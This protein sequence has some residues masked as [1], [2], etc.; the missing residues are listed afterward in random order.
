MAASPRPL[1]TVVTPS[2]N[3]GRFIEETIQSV[4]AQDY[5]PVEH[6]VF[7]AGSTDETH[8]VLARYEGKIRAVIAADD[9]QADAINRG[10]RA[11]A[12]TIV[13]WLNSDDV[14][15]PGAIRTAVEYLEAHPQCAMVYGKGHHIDAEGRF[16]DPYPTAPPSELEVFC[17]VCQPASFLRLA[18]VHAVGYLDPN[19]RYCMDY[20]LWLRLR[21]QFDIAYIPADLARSR[22]HA[23]AKSVSQQRAFMREIIGMTMRRIGRAPLVYL[24]GYANMLVCE[25][26]RERPLPTP[27]RRLAAG[28]V[29][30]TLALRYHRRLRIGEIR[31]ALNRAIEISRL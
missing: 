8:S 28:I 18:A 26:F 16:L 19:L 20:D 11:A 27:I 23:D 3:Q 6:L 24:Y 22:L 2:L 21:E 4:L 29:T 5:E 13:T 15:E 14:Y 9:G 12:G 10:F 31:H 17:T 30:A 25:R 1:V 7:D